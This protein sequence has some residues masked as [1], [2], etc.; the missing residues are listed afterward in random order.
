MMLVTTRSFAY[1]SFEARYGPCFY[2]YPCSPSI[3]YLA[4]HSCL[5]QTHYISERSRSHYRPPQYDTTRVDSV[6]S[7]LYSVSSLSVRDGVRTGVDRNL[8]T[9]CDCVLAGRARV[10]R[11]FIRYSMFVSAVITYVVGLQDEF[12]SEA[13]HSNGSTTATGRL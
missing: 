13:L 5:K 10:L 2:P 4:H 8:P 3:S 11:E 1:D 12:T 6:T 7:D 9:S